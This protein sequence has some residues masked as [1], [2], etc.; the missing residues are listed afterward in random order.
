MTELKKQRKLE[1]LSIILFFFSH[2]QRLFSKNSRKCWRNLP[3]FHTLFHSLLSCFPATWLLFWRKECFRFLE[4]V[5]ISEH[6]YMERWFEETN[7]SQRDILKQRPQ[8]KESTLLTF[9]TALFK[10]S[11]FSVFWHLTWQLTNEFP[12]RPS[13]VWFSDFYSSMNGFQLTKARTFFS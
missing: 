10:K 4:V 6:I 11:K 7:C 2:E 1:K 13:K 3:A 8:E 5:M 12:H 9:G